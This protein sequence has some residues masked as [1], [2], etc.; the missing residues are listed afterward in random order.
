MKKILFA[1]ICFL[2]ICSCHNL[3]EK[4]QEYIVGEWRPITEE[5]GYVYNRGYNF[6]EDGL[7]DNKLGFL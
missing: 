2:L 7:C 1:C 5:D 3:T 4:N 6:M